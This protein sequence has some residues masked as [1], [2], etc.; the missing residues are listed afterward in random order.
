[1]HKIQNR[2]SLHDRLLIERAKAKSHLEKRNLFTRKYWLERLKFVE[3]LLEI[4][5][6]KVKEKS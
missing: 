1:M 6:K 5:E 4:E 3:H 2:I